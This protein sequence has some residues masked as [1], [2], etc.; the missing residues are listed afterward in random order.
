[1]QESLLI[2]ECIEP[3]LLIQS[4]HV[5]LAESAHSIQWPWLP[6]KDDGM[7]LA[8]FIFPINANLRSRCRHRCKQAVLA[9]RSPRRNF[10]RHVCKAAFQGLLGE[11]RSNR[12]DH[13][14]ENHCCDQIPRPS[15]DHA[16]KWSESN[17][18]S[19]SGDTGPCCEKCCV[20]KH[21]DA[22]DEGEPIEETV[23]AGHRDANHQQC[24]DACSQGSQHPRPEQQERANQFNQ[25]HGGTT[26]PQNP[27]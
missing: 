10:T 16:R 23:V 14:A 22:K 20:I 6:S 12:E 8:L 21:G 7:P 27:R 3:E 4:W 15:R 24:N 5:G 17:N 25:E 26:G 1:M 13:Q 11:L 9:H 18:N 19:R 2:A